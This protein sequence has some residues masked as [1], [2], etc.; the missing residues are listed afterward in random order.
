MTLY[1]SAIFILAESNLLKTSPP[2]PSLVLMDVFYKSIPISHM[3]PFA[4]RLV[5]LGVK[6]IHSN[7][8]HV[9]SGLQYYNPFDKKIPASSH[10]KG[11][12]AANINLSKGR[13]I[14]S[15]RRRSHSF[16]FQNLP[17]A[18]YSSLFIQSF[19]FC[20]FYHTFLYAASFN[21]KVKL[22]HYFLQHRA[23]NLITFC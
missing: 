15:S 16:F 2:L 7:S 13:L 23:A 6:T 11:L 17:P 14:E 19:L 22:I 20:M 10:Q 18:F 1:F 5:I 3:S 4:L 9:Q 21:F 8:P 12:P